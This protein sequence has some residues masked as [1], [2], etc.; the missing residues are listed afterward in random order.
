MAVYSAWFSE[1][2]CISFLCKSRFLWAWILCCVLSSIWIEWNKPARR[3]KNLQAQDFNES[4]FWRKYLEND[5]LEFCCHFPTNLCNLYAVE[6]KSWAFIWQQVVSAFLY[7]QHWKGWCWQCC[8]PLLLADTSQPWQ[9]SSL[10]FFHT[11]FFILLKP[12]LQQWKSSGFISALSD[13]AD[14][15]IYVTVMSQHLQH[16]RFPCC[17]K[18]FYCE[19]FMCSLF[20]SLHTN[21]K[22]IPRLYSHSSWNFS[23]DSVHL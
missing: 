4:Y 19:S 1:V 23:K 8:L 22:E 18:V 7:L 16:E 5:F 14:T 20:V 6:R 17:Y 11:V 13:I 21:F 2:I 3:K 9:W 10:S 15:K 12:I